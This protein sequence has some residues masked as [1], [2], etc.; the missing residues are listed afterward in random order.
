M[1]DDNEK[2]KVLFKLSVCGKSNIRIRTFSTG[3]LF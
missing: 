3:E 2:L 1:K